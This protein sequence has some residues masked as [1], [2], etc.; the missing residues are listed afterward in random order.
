MS[1]ALN[2][3]R[4]SKGKDDDI[5]LELQRE[6][7]R[8]LSESLADDVDM[9]DLGVHTGFSVHSRDLEDE[10]I[11]SNEDVS[12]A[13]SRIESGEYDYLIAYDD[14]R[15]ARDQYFATIE[16]ACL[17]GNCEICYVADVDEGM[18]FELQ[19]TV[20]KY[21]KQNEIEKSKQAR[22]RR[23]EKGYWEG[24]PRWGTQYDSNKA[25]LEP[26]KNFDDALLAIRMD[27]LDE[28]SY[29][30]IVQTTNISSKGTLTNI[31]ER[32]EWYRD[33]AEEH[34]V[35]IPEIPTEVKASGEL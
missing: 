13:V 20:E 33:L 7:T 2:W 15:I 10:R 16:K 8:D 5:G 4:K 30:D 31:L 21:V 27:K 1:K 19:R 3:I 11:D 24:R 26:G 6:T 14:T 28:P 18:S 23:Q 22:Q 32:A 17:V 25:Y 35:K 12:D 29:D 34:E 9:L